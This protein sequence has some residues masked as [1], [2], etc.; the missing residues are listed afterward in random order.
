MP[1]CMRRRRDEHATRD[2]ARQH[3]R[4]GGRAGRP[5]LGSV[6]APSPNPPGDTRAAA[7]VLARWMEARGVP[8]RL[9]G[10]DPAMPNILASFE[11]ARPGPHL[12]LNGHIDTF[13][14]AARHRWTRDPL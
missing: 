6:R 11:G 4:R 14:L 8:F 5:A 7:A 12:V 1:G 10:P 13:P 9:L 3:R 2:A